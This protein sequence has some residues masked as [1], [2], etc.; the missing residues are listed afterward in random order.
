MTTPRKRPVRIYPV[1]GVSLYPW[2]AIEQEVSAEDWA[3]LQ[4]ARPQP[5][6]DIPPGAQPDQ[7]QEPDDGSPDTG[8]LD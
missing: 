6:T 1:P 7:P 2:R 8:G 5:F 3:T 4:E